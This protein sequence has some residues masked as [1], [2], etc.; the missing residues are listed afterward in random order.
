M[1]TIVTLRMTTAPITT[2][3]PITANLMIQDI[4]SATS[5]RD[6]SPVIL[7]RHFSFADCTGKP[8]ILGFIQVGILADS[9]RDLI[10]DFSD[11][12]LSALRRESNFSEEQVWLRSFYLPKPLTGLPYVL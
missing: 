4:C 10:L 3:D 8:I 11:R 9:I 7:I 5:T 1:A 2:Q 6:I 12:H